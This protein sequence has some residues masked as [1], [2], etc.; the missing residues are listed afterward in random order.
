MRSAPLRLTVTFR[1]E[2]FVDEFYRFFISFGVAAGDVFAFKAEALVEF[3]YTL[4]VE[5]PV[6]GD[7]F[8][9]VAVLYPFNV[10]FGVENEVV[11]IEFR[12]CL[13][14]I[15]VCFVSVFEEVHE[16]TGDE[17]VGV[18]NQNFVAVFDETHFL[19]LVFKE[20]PRE[21]FGEHH[22]VGAG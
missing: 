15:F 19:G 13:S 6:C 4:A 9:A 14:Q 2:K 3:F 1:E 8:A 20:Y 11:V 22:G 10:R 21:V 17:A 5:F 7:L 18:F 16:E 12:Y